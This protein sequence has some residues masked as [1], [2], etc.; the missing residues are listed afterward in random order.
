M[1]MQ[2]ENRQ[3]LRDFNRGVVVVLDKLV[4]DYP[5]SFED[6]LSCAI[7]VCQQQALNIVEREQILE[8]EKDDAS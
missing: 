8:K 5:L 4:E 1:K 2:K 7:Q 6:A 3:Y